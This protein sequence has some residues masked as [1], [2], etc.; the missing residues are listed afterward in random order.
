MLDSLTAT[1]AAVA[2][3]GAFATYCYFLQK[4]ES[5]PLGE[6]LVDE[7]V[8]KNESILMLLMMGAS[9]G[10]ALQAATVFSPDIKI[11]TAVI[12][13]IVGHL[14]ISVTGMVATLTFFR[15]VG[16][17]FEAGLDKHSR[18]ARFIVILIVFLMMVGAPIANTILL[19]GNLKQ[20]VI[21]DL[22][23]V[24]WNPFIGDE[25][26]IRILQIWGYAPTWSAWAAMETALK[27]SWIINLFHFSIAILE[28]VRSV[29]SKS[30][31]KRLLFKED[32]KTEEDSSKKKNDKKDERKDDD[33]ETM[34]GEKRHYEA[35]SKNITFL[36]SRIGYREKTK[37]ESMVK[38]A[39]KV[40]DDTYTAKQ[41]V[42]MGIAARLAALV[43]EGKTIDQDDR[44]DKA[45]A[46]AKLKKDIY[47]IFE[48]PLKAKGN[49]D[50][51]GDFLSP[52]AAGLG[53]KLSA[54]P[55]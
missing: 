33:S 5:R 42:A 41:R 38:A 18:F 6:L 14:F 15:D 32:D 51:G 2:A 12:S 26:Y 10:E 52:T 3:I 9:V 22:F 48:N 36:L 8:L 11:H 1:L 17:L 19:A 49:G 20:E 24:S 39:V 13:R 50:K 37:L 43:A 44:T 46:K 53:M 55:K 54:S 40:L 31:R 25:E 30:R 4:G 28:G 7:A 16:A 35:V 47:L 45:A 34:A 23:F 21:L 29:S 27:M